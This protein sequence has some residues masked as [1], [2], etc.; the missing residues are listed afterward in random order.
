MK[1]N[2][3]FWLVYIVYTALRYIYSNLFFAVDSMEDDKEIADSDHIEGVQVDK[4]QEIESMEGY[5]FS[6]DE[7]SNEE[8][9][10]FKNI[11]ALNPDNN[12]EKVT[13][14]WKKF[15]RPQIYW[16]STLRTN[17]TETNDENYCWVITSKDKKPE[18]VEFSA[19]GKWIDHSFDCNHGLFPIK[20]KDQWLIPIKI[21]G[22]NHSIRRTST[23]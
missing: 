6:E 21:N 13:K 16:F 14:V 23:W 19:F 8:S 17:L 15:Q 5:K 22:W 9:I 1:R 20:F 2:N 3:Y 12:F 4:N 7:S 10:I 18:N 11:N